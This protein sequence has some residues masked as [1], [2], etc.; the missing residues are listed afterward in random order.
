MWRLHNNVMVLF[1]HWATVFWGNYFFFSKGVTQIFFPRWNFF[2]EVV[3]AYYIECPD[4]QAPH[5]QKRRTTTVNCSSCPHGNCDSEKWRPVFWGNYFFFSKGVT[6][7]SRRFCAGGCWRPAQADVDVSDHQSSNRNSVF[8]MTM[9]SHDTM[10]S[11]WR[12][13]RS[14]CAYRSSSCAALRAAAA[15]CC[16][17]IFFFSLENF[18]CGGW[19]RSSLTT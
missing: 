9:D 18:L 1:L 19:R 16:C 13:P 14:S 11:L 8:P 3:V 4:A 2:C 12:H 10:L 7:K 15:W 17:K 6:Q 5:V